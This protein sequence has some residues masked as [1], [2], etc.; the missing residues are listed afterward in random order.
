MSCSN[1]FSGDF[2]HVVGKVGS[3]YT[4]NLCLNFASQVFVELSDLHSRR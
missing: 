2:E 1:Y 4:L 3:S